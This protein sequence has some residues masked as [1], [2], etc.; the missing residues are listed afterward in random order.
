MTRILAAILLILL[1]VVAIA[2]GVWGLS[3]RATSDIPTEVLSAAQT[4]LQYA[5]STVN[6]L[7]GKIAGWTNN[8]FTLTGLLNTVA[9]DEVD[10]TSKAS[11]EVFMM[12]HAVEI[13]LG[14]IVGVE[15][16]LLMFKRRS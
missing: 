3:L 12:L 10:L 4:V 13:L 14:G 8:T 5:D 6:G 7:D 16:G 15:T 9:G 11:T 1:G 2:G